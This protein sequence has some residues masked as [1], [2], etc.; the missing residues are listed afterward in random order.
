M[1][2]I[3]LILGGHSFISQLGSD[4]A[5]SEQVQRT[6]VESCLDNG[7]RWFDTTYQP[8][9]VA[10]GTLLHALGR[11]REATIFAWNF[12]TDFVPGEPVGEASYYAP[13]HIDMILEQLRTDYVDCLVIV[14]LDDAEK[15]RQQEEL[16][17][18]WKN[19]GY[20][21]SLGLWIRDTAIVDRRRDENPFRFAIRPF[22]V[23]TAADASIFAAC[24]AAGWETLATSPFFRGWELDRIV[25]EAGAHGYGDAATLRALLADLML[26]FSLFQGGIDRLIVAMRKPEWIRRNLESVARGPLT[27]HDHRKLQRLRSLGTK[28]DPWWRRLFQRV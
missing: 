7:I 22:N 1:T 14:P 18:D 23:T 11:R 10:L 12:F 5:A 15:N 8:E 2:E 4:P 13:G 19:K 3:P 28:S 16:A 26:R 25:T 6:I 20:V 27:A 24:K 9:R 21:R 17:L